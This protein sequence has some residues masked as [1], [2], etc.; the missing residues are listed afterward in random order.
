MSVLLLRLAG[1][2]QSWGTQSRF[3][4]RDT[5]LDPTKSGVVGLLGA[6]LGVPRQDSQTIQ[7]L[8]RLK[9]AVRIDRPGIMKRDYHTAMDVRKADGSRPPAGQAVVSERFFLADADFL[10]GLEGDALFLRQIDQSIREP[11]WP[12]FLGRKS[13]V[14]ARPIFVEEGLMDVG[15]LP[16][17]ESFPFEPET[18]AGNK[19]DRLRVVYEVDNPAE[20]EPRYDV[21]LS[22]EPRR[23]TLRHVASK[24]I[25]APVRLEVNP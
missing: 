20:G 7:R 16:A 21:P 8:A 22:F 18:S 15:L 3:L 14:P 10:V 1:P 19:V 12:I 13:F 6:A 25:D 23:F 2:M 24:M 9:M 17:L 11:V 4:H 5:G